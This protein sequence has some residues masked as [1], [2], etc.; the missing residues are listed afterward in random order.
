MACLWLKTPVYRLKCYID[1]DFPESLFFSEV[2][3]RINISNLKVLYVTGPEKLDLKTVS[4]YQVILC[5]LNYVEAVS[6]IAMDLVINT[7]S[8]KEMTDDW[9]DFCINW[10][11]VHDCRWFYSAN[12][13][14]S[15]LYQMQETR[16]T[17]SP[18]LTPEWRIKLQ[19]Y[20][21]AFMKIH[22]IFNR[23]VAEILAQK[24]PAAGKIDPETARMQYRRTQEKILDGQVL[25][26]ALDIVHSC[27][28]EEIM[29]DL[30][31]RCTTEMPVIPKEALYLAQYLKKNAGAAFIKQHE[32]GLEK[33]IE[34][35][36]LVQTGKTEKI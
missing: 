11:K 14:A 33:L 6:D 25:L 35:L 26:E 16:S 3:L 24:Q 9:V 19:R 27:P 31:L 18:R 23:N 20:N 12:Y 7:G 28:D 21:P 32:T 4:Q 10:L 13:F 22:G 30:L 1:I 36:Y 17:W 15:P 2:F 5:P 34:K 29:W 8:M